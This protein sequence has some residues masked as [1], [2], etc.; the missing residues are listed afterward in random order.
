MG[1]ILYSEQGELS[2]AIEKEFFIFNIT[3]HST[4]MNNCFISFLKSDVYT[5]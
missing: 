5:L 2:L 4:K 1:C 3:S